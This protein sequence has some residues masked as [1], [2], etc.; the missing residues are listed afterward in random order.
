MSDEMQRKMFGV[1]G[2]VRATG[3]YQPDPEQLLRALEFPQCVTRQFCSG[4]GALYE[5]YES[6][7]KELVQKCHTNS[8]RIGSGFFKTAGC[9]ACD[10][11]RD[12][13]EFVTLASLKS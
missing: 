13:V 7:A 1:V 4:C 2:V 12:K 8:V 9:V 10:G 6:F 3:G 11:D 5:I